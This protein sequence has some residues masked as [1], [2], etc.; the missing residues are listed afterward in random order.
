MSL[1]PIVADVSGPYTLDRLTSQ[2]SRPAA[3]IRSPRLLTA[4]VRQPEA[5]VDIPESVQPFWDKFQASI[6]YDALPLFYE[7]F[8]F[9]DNERTANALGALVL[10]G[11]KRATTG[12]LWTNEQT[13]KPL[14]KIDS[15]S[16]VTD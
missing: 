2:W 13:S 3:R 1:D 15:L 4:D 6:T 8:H 16:V 14:P 7:A 5:M 10:S 9:D 12:L 11:R